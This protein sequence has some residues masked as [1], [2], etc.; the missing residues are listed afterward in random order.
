MAPDAGDFHLG[1]ASPARDAGAALSSPPP[2]D[3]DG[4]P[5]PLTGASAGAFE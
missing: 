2:L 4:L 5:R 3:F 1:P